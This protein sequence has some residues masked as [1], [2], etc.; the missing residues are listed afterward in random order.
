ME[1]LNNDQKAVIYDDCIRETDR[2]QR[3]NSRI[4]SDHTGNIPPVLQKEINENERKIANLIRRVENLF[5]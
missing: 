3:V 5:L 1:N 2:L 4:K